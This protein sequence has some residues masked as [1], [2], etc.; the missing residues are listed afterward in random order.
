MKEKGLKSRL[1]LYPG[2]G[3]NLLF[4]SFAAAWVVV[5]LTGCA[6][7]FDSSFDSGMDRYG[8][9][10]LK[11]VKQIFYREKNE[12]NAMESTPGD[13]STTAV[14]SADEYKWRKRKTRETYCF[15]SHA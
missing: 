4:R 7:A 12:T 8:F 1:R 5:G 2:G 11:N 3:I 14:L 10:L 6:A 9:G 13:E 15:L